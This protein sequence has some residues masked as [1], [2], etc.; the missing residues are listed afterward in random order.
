M[1]PPT[2]RG[3]PHFGLG[4]FFHPFAHCHLPQPLSEHASSVLQFFNLVEDF[5]SRAQDD[6]NVVTCQHV[7]GCYI[8]MSGLRR[9]GE[10]LMVRGVTVVIP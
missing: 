5:G 8:F 7:A 10:V 9:R 4:G 2:V 1:T 6:L 3:Q